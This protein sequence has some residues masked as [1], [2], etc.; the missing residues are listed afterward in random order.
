M[1]ISFAVAGSATRP[2]PRWLPARV[3]EH[4]FQ[5]IVVGIAGV[6]ADGWSP[7]PMH[8]HRPEL[9][10]RL[11]EACSAIRVEPFVGPEEART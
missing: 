2:P 3:V 11:G 5:Q 6:E 8:V 7:R 1:L 4:E 9:H 10:L